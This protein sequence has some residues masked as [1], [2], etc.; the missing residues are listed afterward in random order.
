MPMRFYPS[1]QAMRLA[2]RMID[3]IADRV[4]GYRGRLGAA[5]YWNLH[6]GIVVTMQLD[7][8]VTEQRWDILRA[9]AVTP[10]VGLFSA[11]EFP[12]GIYGTLTESPPFIHDLDGVAEWSNRLYF[13]MG[14]LIEDAVLWMSTLIAAILD[15]Q[16]HP[17][18]AFPA[19]TA[20]ERELVAYALEELNGH[21]QL[22][23]LH[24]AF[25]GRISYRALGNLAAL[26]ET[27]GLLTENPR[28]VTV[29]L[30]V[31]VDH[32]TRAAAALTEDADTDQA[33]EDNS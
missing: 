20:L 10:A 30:R 13:Q 1:Y 17:P 15:P 12:F 31:L 3:V 27:T 6:G 4:P 9:E 29:A 19:L 8:T 22:K 33:S 16:V 26:W 24:N 2:D 25:K 32:G 7:F 18:A 14:Y 5:W 21:F 28:R 23:A 11:A